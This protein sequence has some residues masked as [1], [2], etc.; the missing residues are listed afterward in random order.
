MHF[1]FKHFKIEN[2]ENFVI[3]TFAVKFSEEEEDIKVKQDYTLIYIYIY[4]KD[5]FLYNE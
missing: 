5:L 3:H 2:N 4:N 1:L